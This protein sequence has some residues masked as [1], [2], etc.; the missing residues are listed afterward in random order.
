LYSSSIAVSVNNIITK[1][2]VDTRAAISLIHETAL[3][4]M[5]HKPIDDE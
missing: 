2:L 4:P 1:V 3:Q 5:Q